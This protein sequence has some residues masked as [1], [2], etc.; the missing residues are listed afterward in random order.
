M[1]KSYFF[2]NGSTYVRASSRLPLKVGQ[3]FSNAN[4]KKSKGSKVEL[5]DEMN[6]S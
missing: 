6:E 3:E 2:C 4:E 5:N 1:A